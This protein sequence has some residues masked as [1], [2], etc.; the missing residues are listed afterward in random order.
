MRLML[1][2]RVSLA[3]LSNHAQN[4]QS[5][6]WEHLNKKLNRKIKKILRRLIKK[7]MVKKHLLLMTNPRL[8]PQNQPWVRQVECKLNLPKKSNL[9]LNLQRVFFL[10]HLNSKR[11]KTKLIF[12]MWLISIPM[13]L[14]TG[15]LF[16]EKFL[17]QL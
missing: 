11:I 1:K 13:S 3:H 4:L 7:F 14:I 17:V 2:L 9:V 10:K 12:Q 6:E 5:K 8:Y 16:A 15:N